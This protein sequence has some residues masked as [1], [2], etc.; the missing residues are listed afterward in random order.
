MEIHFWVHHESGCVFCTFDD[1]Y[2][3]CFD[4]NEPIEEVSLAMFQLLRSKGYTCDAFSKALL[5]QAIYE[6]G[7]K[8]V[9]R[10]D[11]ETLAVVVKASSVCKSIN[12]VIQQARA[13]AERETMLARF[14]KLGFTIVGDEVFKDEKD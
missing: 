8:A 12:S 1:E 10:K 11:M 6:F 13:D 14:R 7:A 9:L 4:H 5:L 3:R 2:E